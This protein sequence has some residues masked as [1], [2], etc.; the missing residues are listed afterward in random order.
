MTTVQ[1]KTNGPMDADDIAG[2]LPFY[3]TGGL[4]AAEQARVARWLDGR[5]DRAGVL[6]R[7][8]EEQEAT[9]RINEAI[10]PPRAALGKLMASIEAEPERAFSPVRPAAILRGLLD[11]L[12]ALPPALAWGAAALLLLVTLGQSVLMVA[13]PAPGDYILAGGEQLKLDGPVIIVAFQPTA[14]H[15]AMVT[16]LEASGATILAG[17]KGA[18]LYEV[19]FVAG[20]GTGTLEERLQLLVQRTD[21]VA[22]HTI[23]GK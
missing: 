17:P 16:A 21:L 13:H 4:D 20:R 2:L 8:A 18:G 15:A 11:R 9:I 3:V 10:T 22:F 6:A 19:G 23:R 12:F 1:A 7:V 14:T 5:P